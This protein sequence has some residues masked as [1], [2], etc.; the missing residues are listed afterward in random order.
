MKTL[1]IFMFIP[2]SLFAASAG[3]G[4]Y[5]I[6]P[7]TINFLIFAAILVYLLAKP[8]KAFYENRIERISTRLQ[9]I[10]QKVLESKNQKLELMKKL[11][12]AKKDSIIAINDAQKE[13]VLLA[14]KIKNE[15]KNDIALLEK[16]F[17]E[18]KQYEQR[19]MQKELISTMLA[20]VFAD[21]ELRLKQ[22]EIVNIM[23]KKVS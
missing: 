4:E 10:Q 15:V 19:K 1:F 16:Q 13:A 8:A 23:L 22:N 6:L 17:E 20:K 11:E 12:D 3:S 9:D 21:E 5:D 7:R 14:E 18:Q 2:L